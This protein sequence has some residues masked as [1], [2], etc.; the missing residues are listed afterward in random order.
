M[1]LLTITCILHIL[2]CSSVTRP[3][4]LSTHFK[5]SSAYLVLWLAYSTLCLAYC[6]PACHTFC[7]FT[8]C[9]YSSL[10]S[11]SALLLLHTGQ[12]SP[13][14]P[15]A[16]LHL[17]CLSASSVRPTTCTTVPLCDMPSACL[18][19]LLYAIALLCP[20]AS[21]ALFCKRLYRAMAISVENQ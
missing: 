4:C 19:C 12:P 8:T 20:L 15:S 17:P 13:Y 9:L 1:S 16:A 6:D 7:P 11:S 18:P 21:L 2:L 14:L 10:S 5:P 3:A